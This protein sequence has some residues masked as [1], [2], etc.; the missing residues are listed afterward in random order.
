MRNHHRETVENEKQRK[1][2]IQTANKTKIY[3]KEYKVTAVFTNA[4][5]KTQRNMEWYPQNT[6]KKKK[7]IACQCC[8]Q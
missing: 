5:I 2:Q 6:K 7:S 1:N 8:M 4:T 3:F